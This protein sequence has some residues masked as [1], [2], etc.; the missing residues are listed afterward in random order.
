MSS[1]SS[2][3]FLKSDIIKGATAA[4]SSPVA[5]HATVQLY[6]SS[7]G[8]RC[9]ETKQVYPWR[10]W[11]SERNLYTHRHMQ[12]HTSCRSK[13]YLQRVMVMVKVQAFYTCLLLIADKGQR[14][15]IR[16]LT[17]SQLKCG[18]QWVCT[19]GPFSLH[20]CFSIFSAFHAAYSAP[21]VL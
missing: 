11:E 12:R 14:D 19:L 10:V 6:S 17:C 1:C 5:S 8:R 3:L 21:V 20:H 4:A 2:F 13:H 7:W 15:E 16:S 18:A 9:W